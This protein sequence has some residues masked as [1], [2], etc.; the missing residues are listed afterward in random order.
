MNRV[1]ISSACLLTA[2]LALAGPLDP[3]VPPHDPTVAREGAI[4]ITPSPESPKIVISVPGSYYLTG[5]IVGTAGDNG[6]EISANNVSLDL[7][8]FSVIG[9]PGSLDGIKTTVPNRINIRVYNGT[10]RGWGDEGI[11]LA[12]SLNSVVEDVQAAANA[13]DGIYIGRGSIQHCQ[14]R[15]NGAAGIRVQG[16]SQIL[17]CHLSGNSGSGII[18][19]DAVLVRDCISEANGVHGFEVGNSCT[20]SGSQAI[21]NAFHGIAAG[22]KSAITQT[23]ATENGATGISTFFGAMIAQCTS[24]NNTFN[25]I[26][27]GTSCTIVDNVVTDNSQRGIHCAGVSVIS[28]NTCSFNTTEG[29]VSDGQSLIE[30]N[31]CSFNAAAGIR[32]TGADSTIDSNLLIGNGRGLDIDLGGNVIVRNRAS[33]NSVANFDIVPGNSGLFVSASVG[34]GVFGSSGGSSLGSSDPWA[35]FSF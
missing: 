12:S 27:T 2:G 23:L 10:V 9:V 29:L 5:S 3:I 4:P 6:I 31:N 32:T 17:S 33:S 8:G 14:A 28:R 15:G 18:G 20:I 11:E 30:S 34:A 25:G 16:A 7:R 35:N 21:K 26:T 22:E 1:G 19:S 13:G 24:A